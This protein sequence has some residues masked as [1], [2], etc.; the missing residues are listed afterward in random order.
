MKENDTTDKT[1]NRRAFLGTVAGAATIFAGC[2]SDSG[3]GQAETTETVANETGASTTTES[4]TPAETPTPTPPDAAIEHLDTA[5]DE[6]TA[7]FTTLR[8]ANV[9]DVEN[10]L[11]HLDF[12]AL[13]AF[14]PEPVLDGVSTATD[15]LHD[16]REE[17]RDEAPKLHTVNALLSLTVIARAGAMLY[18]EIRTTYTGVWNGLKARQRS[19]DAEA[20]E[21][22][23]DVIET[24]ERW[25]EPAE[26]L[27]DGIKSMRTTGYPP[28][29]DGF[30]SLRWEKIARLGRE[31]PSEFRRIGLAQRAF[32]KA[33]VSYL[34]GLFA[35]DDEEWETAMRNLEVAQPLYYTAYENAASLREDDTYGFYQTIVDALHCEGSKMRRGSRYLMEAA[36]AYSAGNSE[37]GNQKEKK[38]RDEVLEATNHCTDFPVSR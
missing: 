11:Y 3:S 8:K 33:G 1:S 18:P 12:E 22:M 20:L 36:Q 6:L 24:P 15:A 9:Y 35:F 13:R 7:A 26:E 29:V 23:K 10:R 25:E 32:T 14:D 19:D 37:K 16:S 34:D 17:L 5:R 21:Y 28:G 38:G 27:T 31:A 30:E 4:P 2:S